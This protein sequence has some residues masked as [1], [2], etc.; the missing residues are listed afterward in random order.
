MRFRHYLLC[1]KFKLYTEH[2]ALKHVLNMRDL[3]RRIARWLNLLTE[4]DFEIAY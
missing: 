3:N 1:Q 4:F 2:E